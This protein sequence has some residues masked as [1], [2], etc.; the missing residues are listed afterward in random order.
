MLSDP[1][2]VPAGSEGIAQ[3]R[4]GLRL[5]GKSEAGWVATLHG[6][7]ETGW[8][9]TLKG[10]DREAQGETLGMDGIVLRGTLQGSDRV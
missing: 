10:S 4:T 1:F 8:V 6:K 9:T 3:L 2:G 5:A 7:S